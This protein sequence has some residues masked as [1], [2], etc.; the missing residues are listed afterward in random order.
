M[1]E[2]LF[3][4]VNGRGPVDMKELV[5]DDYSLFPMGGRPLKQQPSAGMLKSEAVLAAAVDKEGY[6]VDPWGNRYQI[7]PGTGR[8][9]SATEGYEAW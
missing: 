7:Q 2:K 4:I 3:T 6:P 5:N 1:Q 8:I 9:H